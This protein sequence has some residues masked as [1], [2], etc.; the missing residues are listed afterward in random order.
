MLTVTE[1]RNS[2]DQ[3]ACIQVKCILVMYR[4]SL[5]KDRTA[6]WVVFTIHFLGQSCS[7]CK[8]DYVLTHAL[9]ES[10][11]LEIYDIVQESW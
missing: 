11:R 7:A 9:S 3:H 4:L 10:I 1:N 6:T 5:W 2:S 8:V